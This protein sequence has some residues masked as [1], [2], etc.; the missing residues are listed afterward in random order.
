MSS[1]FA[2]IPRKIAKQVRRQDDH[3]GSGTRDEVTASSHKDALV[4][5][6]VTETQTSHTKAKAKPAVKD[7]AGDHAGSSYNDEDYAVLIS[8]A[9][10]DY[11]L[12]CDPDLR[13]KRDSKED[14]DELC[15]SYL[16]SSMTT[17]DEFYKSSRFVISCSILLS[18]LRLVLVIQN[19]LNWPLRKPCE[20]LPATYLT[21]A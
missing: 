16:P 10:S 8:I 7:S 6:S 20:Q 13:R 19:P 14:G 3:G 9:L 18:C 12:W 1:P 11:A 2:F 21:S 15:E 5:V 4:E 17:F